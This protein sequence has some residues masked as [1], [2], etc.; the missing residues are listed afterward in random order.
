MTWNSYW[1]SV[2]AVLGLAIGLAGFRK[3]DK[4]PVG[5]MSWA[6]AACLLYWGFGMAVSFLG[7]WAAGL[8]G[9]IRDGIRQGGWVGY[10]ALGT[11]IILTTATAFGLFTGF[12]DIIKDRKPDQPA[13]IVCMFIFLAVLVVLGTV[14]GPKIHDRMFGKV[15]ASV[16]QNG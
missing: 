15:G 2:W 4:M 16:A 3:K 9:W 13:Y 10:I 7:A 8:G 5:F 12:K 1:V 6:A 14:A 11:A